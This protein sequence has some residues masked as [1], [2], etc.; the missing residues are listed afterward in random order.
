MTGSIVASG[1]AAGDGSKAEDQCRS[2]TATARYVGEEW[3]NGAIPSRYA[4]RTLDKAVSKLA[5][6]ATCERSAGSAAALRT[7]MSRGAPVEVQRA[8]AGVDG[9]AG[10]EAAP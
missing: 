3:L 8:L 1:S 9:V 10:D 6:H 7:A 4:V 2:W 5:E